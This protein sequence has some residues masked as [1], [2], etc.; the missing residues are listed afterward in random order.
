VNAPELA[1]HHQRLA[2]RAA[3]LR[4]QIERRQAELSSD[5]ETERLDRALQAAAAARQDLELRLRDRDREVESHRGRLRTR[6]RELMSGRIKNPT[7]LVKLDAEVRHLKTAL[8]SEEDAE[9]E[10][11]EEQERLEGEVGR[12]GQALEAARARV[13]ET[14][15]ALRERIARGGSRAGCGLLGG[16]LDLGAAAG[17]LAHRLW[18][19]RRPDGEPDRRGGGE[20]VPGLPRD[21]HHQRHAGVAAGRTPPVR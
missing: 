11:M 1:L 19:G 21:G 14:A 2:A 4:G 7:E 17:E 20:P 6:E 15:P 9:L 16:R 5:Q 10:L 12:L 18:A 3:L 13:A 8:R